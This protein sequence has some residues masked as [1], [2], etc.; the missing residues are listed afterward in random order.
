MAALPGHLALFVLCGATFPTRSPDLAQAP[1]AETATRLVLHESP[2]VDLYFHVRSV[3]VTASGGHRI[4][5]LDPAIEAARELDRSLGGSPLAWGPLEGL[6]TGCRTA[7]DVQRAFARAPETLELR[8][9]RRVELRAPAAK[10]AA[11]L[12][13]AEAAFQEPAK[14][15]AQRIA[16]ARAAWEERVAPNWRTCLEFHL[17]S[18]GMLDP[19]I[20]I[21]VYLVAELPPPGAITHRTERDEGVCFVGVDAAQGSQLF[22]V[23]LHEATHALDLATRNESALGELRRELQASGL[24]SEHRA[25]RDLPHLLMFVQSAETVRRLLDPAHRDYGEAARVYE[26]LPGAEAVR[27]HWREHLDGK[28]TRAQALKGILA[29]LEPAAK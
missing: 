29:S 12:V 6:L 21:P 3:A 9:G 27:S 24:P 25:H 8:D 11:A 20:E 26:R 13:A 5:E 28:Q 16:A 15:R 1:P 23:I 22:E 18:L 7:A 4:R 2:A 14:R 19:E 17:G 10:L